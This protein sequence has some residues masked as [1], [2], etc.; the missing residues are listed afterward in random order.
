MATEKALVRKFPGTI[1]KD[2]R[3]TCAY[4]IL[5]PGKTNWYH[6]TY[7]GCYAGL[8]IGEDVKASTATVLLRSGFGL[9]AQTFSNRLF[10]NMLKVFQEHGFF[11]PEMELE[12]DSVKN[13]W[14]V[15]LRP[16]TYNML[17]LKIAAFTYRYFDAAPYAMLLA[18][19]QYLA[20]KNEGVSFY[21]CFHWACNTQ[22][23]H[24]GHGIYNFG[25]KA[26]GTVAHSPYLTRALAYLLN[27]PR[28]EITKIS[29]TRYSRMHVV[30]T[31]DKLY[32]YMR[33]ERT[34][35]DLSVNEEIELKRWSSERHPVS[36]D[37]LLD[38]RFGKLLQTPL[39]PNRV[40][41]RTII[42]TLPKI[43]IRKSYGYYDD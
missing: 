14:S 6:S 34:K 4:S 38:P 39:R 43:T 13:R 15:L 23:M 17:T 28:E 1:R 12:W 41:M 42:Q 40:K 5:A 29:N 33:G 20:L 32:L 10:K 26:G 18:Y 2:R 22:Q 30:T 37:D 3:D 24:S 31:L 7:P 9:H 25:N 27:M 19:R 36:Q 8:F 11:P 21:Q 35:Q 16:Q